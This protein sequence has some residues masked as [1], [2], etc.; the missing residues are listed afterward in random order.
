LGG[1]FFKLLSKLTVMANFQT[2]INWTL[3]NKEVLNFEVERLNYTEQ[4]LPGFHDLRV[5]L[6]YK[7]MNFVGRSVAESMT[8]ALG[9]A[10]SEAIERAVCKLN[11]ADI[12]GTAAH[13]DF[14]LAKANA[15]FELL[16]RDSVLCHFL[17]GIPFNRIEPELDFQPP[18]EVWQKNK[19]EFRFYATSI[20]PKDVHVVICVAEFL[21][22]E[23]A[24]LGTNHMVFGFGAANSLSLASKKSL[25]ECIQ[26]VPVVHNKAIVQI[27]SLSDFH[28]KSIWSPLDH[29]YLGLDPK[30]TQIIR[31]YFQSNLKAPIEDHNSFCPDFEY[32]ELKESDFFTE[33]GLVVVSAA[34]SELQKYFFGPTDGSKLNLRRLS[35]VS[36][37]LIDENTVIKFPHFIG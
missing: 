26:N 1:T 7:G 11:G 6:I 12:S 2:L 25:L 9:K 4:W 5:S 21:G 10:I 18:A 15:R 31:N 29:L 13:F 28:A 32:K 14:H 17:C 30:Y 3:K 24:Q 33:S 16:E 22:K 8:E 27:T 20:Q 36:E 34:S 37:R 19:I 23:N 35:L